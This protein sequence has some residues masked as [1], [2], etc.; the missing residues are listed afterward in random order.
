MTFL[1]SASK[2]LNITWKFSGSISLSPSAN[3]AAVFQGHLLLFHRSIGYSRGERNITD[4]NFRSNLAVSPFSGSGALAFRVRCYFFRQ[5]NGHIAGAFDALFPFLP[6]RVKA[7]CGRSSSRDIL[8]SLALA[9]ALSGAT[10]GFTG[11]LFAL[12]FV[13]LV[14]IRLAAFAIA[15]LLLVFFLTLILRR[16]LCQVPLLH[17]FVG[18]SIRIAFLIT[19]TALTLFAPALVFLLLILPSVRLL[20]QILQR[21]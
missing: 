1:T 12:V 8:R 11:R 18:L 15:V 4:R 21:A 13:T 9:A 3:H 20:L 6:A 17:F 10:F 7:F 14:W 2:R 19:A 16:A 5:L